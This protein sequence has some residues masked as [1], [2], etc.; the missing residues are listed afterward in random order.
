MDVASKYKSLALAFNQVYCHIT[1]TLSMKRNVRNVS[2]ANEPAV[3][4]SH[5]IQVAVPVTCVQA[6]RTS[7]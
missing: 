3:H 1:E 5:Q 7:Q 6:D 2:T 4:K